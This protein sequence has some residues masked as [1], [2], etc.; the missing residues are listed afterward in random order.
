MKKRI[1]IFLNLV[2]LSSTALAQGV[3]T[4]YAM[5]SPYIFE[6][7]PGANV[8]FTIHYYSY[9]ATGVSVKCE[10]NNF[11]QVNSTNPAG[12]YSAGSYN[13]NLGNPSAY[14]HDTIE[15]FTTV[16][17]SAVEG[18]TIKLTVSIS[19][20][21]PGDD[22][23]DNVSECYVLVKYPKPDMWVFHWGLM[24]SLENG[25]FF[26]AEKDVPAKFEI[27]YFN[28]S[29]T[30]AEGLVIT[31]TLPAGVQFISSEPAPTS[32]AGQVVKWNIGSLGAYGY[33]KI[34]YTVKPTTV[35]QNCK[36]IAWANTS[37]DERNLSDNKAAFTFS[38]LALM[39]PIVMKPYTT[40]TD[41]LLMPSNPTFEGL[42]RAG[43]TVSIYEG[44]SDICF[45]FESCN[46]TKIGEAV[47]GPDRKWKITPTGMSE[48]RAYNIYFRASLG[49][50]VSSPAFIWQAKII[51]VEPLFTDSGFD[52]DHFVVETGDQSVAPGALGG[53]SGT[54][55]DVDITIKKRQKAPADFLDHPDQWGVHD[56]KLVVNQQD[57]LNW[58]VTEVQ[59]VQSIGKDN[60]GEET[61]ETVEYD[62][63]YVHKGFGAGATIEVW[64]RP[65]YYYDD[66]TVLAGLVYVKCHEIL[67]DPAGYV[68]DIDLAGSEYKWPA[69]PPEES[70]IKDATVTAYNRTGDTTWSVWDAA[71]SG[72]VNPQVTDTLT[73]DRILVKGYYAFYV[74]SGQYKVEAD[75]PN[76]AGYESPILT[77]VDA[78]VFH[79]VGMRKTVSNIVAVSDEKG[80]EF[81]NKNMPTMFTLYQN[82]PNP[83][84][85][86][87]TMSYYLPKQ[88]NVTLKIYDMLGREVE[89]LINDEI[90]DAGIHQLKFDGSKHSSGV[91]IYMLKAGNQA[92]SKKFILLK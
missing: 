76:Y 37:N 1:L 90:R 70:L 78:P 36:S 64:C 10:N 38:V 91:Y 21:C 26:A 2:I 31:D 20:T 66:G 79:N 50:D 44:Q 12:T 35:A 81:F 18:D 72:Q 19:G 65:V 62:Y 85:P 11:V 24:E 27:H 88:M 49:S 33:G 75:A 46:M 67:I 4:A 89:T 32:V 6:A 47:A 71:A 92:V 84:N 39:Q 23:E 54:V 45:D 61:D 86:Y 17:S 63:I 52:M 14:T 60:G 41:T 59:K 29:F 69:V 68:Y 9:N 58:P 22:P 87:T 55:P 40:S 80:K 3:L 57:T 7:A 51:K 73:E 77:V 16:S 30:P 83:F 8:K 13:W 28:F 53:Q 42:A 43:A 56:M 74:P 82:Y 15:V 25:Y 5:P 48:A 34:D